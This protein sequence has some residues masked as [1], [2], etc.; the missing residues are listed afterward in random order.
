MQTM[1]KL[2]GDADSMNRYTHSEDLTDATSEP[3]FLPN[4]G[5]DLL[6]AV[7]PGQIAGNKSRVE[8]TVS[9][10]KKVEA[11]TAA[12]F[13]WAAGDATTNTFAALSGNLTAVRMVSTGISSWE[14]VV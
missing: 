4:T 9:D 2:T 10:P 8:F 12:W 11:N 3:V 14:L 13:P 5:R 7:L 1:K 6:V